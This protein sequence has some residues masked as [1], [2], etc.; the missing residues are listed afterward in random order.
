MG[1]ATMKED[2]S[3]AET[4]KVCYYSTSGLECG[5]LS[6]SGVW[7]AVMT[8]CVGEQSQVVRGIAR[9]IP[10]KIKIAFALYPAF[11]AIYR[12]ACICG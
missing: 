5:L 10:P 3:L 8:H 1:V 11:P 6:R 4:C 7:A 12:F 2:E 9:P